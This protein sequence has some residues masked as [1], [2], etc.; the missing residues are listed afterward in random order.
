MSSPFKVRIPGSISRRTMEAWWFLRSGLEPVTTKPLNLTM[1]VQTN[2]QT[3]QIGCRLDKQEPRI[4]V[5]PSAGCDKLAK[6]RTLKIIQVNMSGL[7]NKTTELTKVLHD[8]EIDIALLQETILPERDIS[9]PKGYSPY[10]CDC[11]NCQGLMTLIR[12]DIQATVKNNP[13][14]DIDIQ[15]ITLWTN[16]GKF[17]LY[18]F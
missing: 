9:I 3:S 15:E 8:N 5:H 18:N 11:L 13:V 12:T 6:R 7:Q 2:K 17:Y 14:E 10:K 1:T 16:F 4:P